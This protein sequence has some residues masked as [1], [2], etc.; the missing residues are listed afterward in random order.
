MRRLAVCTAMFFLV[1]LASSVARGGRA[2]AY[3]QVSA[4][5]LPWLR[6]TIIEEPGS[7]DVGGV[8]GGLEEHHENDHDRHDAGLEGH[9]GEKA[10]EKAGKEPQT[11]EV[12]P[13]TILSI[14]TNTTEGY[15]LS[16]QSLPSPVFTVVKVELKDRGQSFFL[17]PG[18]SVALHLPYDGKGSD[19]LELSYDFTLS[20]EALP[21]SYPWPIIVSVE[22]L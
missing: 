15:V 11:L 14:T 10:H 6:Y 3:M 16:V 17:G 5:I 8:G 9:Y 12:E 2:V 19:T 7:L 22:P 4:T 20:P 21:G 18:E 13:G 1:I